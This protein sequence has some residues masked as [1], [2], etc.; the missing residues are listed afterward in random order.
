MSERA[1][2]GTTAEARQKQRWRIFCIG[3][4]KTGTSSLNRFFEINGFDSTHNPQW[5]YYSYI[6][7][8]KEWFN[9]SDCYTDGECADFRR[10]QAWFPTS[11]FVLNTRDE[12]RWLRSR[13]KHV[14]RHQITPVRGAETPL[15]LGSMAR[16]F[17]A[18][19]QLAIDD[20]IATR[21]NYHAHVRAALGASDRFTE[22]R[23]TEDK[24]WPVKLAAF[25]RRN[26]VCDAIPSEQE[27]V[28]ANR[29]SVGKDFPRSRPFSTLSTSASRPQA[30][31]IRFLQPARS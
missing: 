24:E 19:P 30:R 22:I 8:G 2:P 4:N 16:E 29:R 15:W 6:M 10:L 25:I 28:Y 23:V 1:D 27:V 18:A 11:L 3:F 5:P 31:R 17:V 21:R 20:W 9:R 12:R 26:G 14:F 7:S 13:V